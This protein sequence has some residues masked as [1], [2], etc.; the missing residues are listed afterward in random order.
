[1]GHGMVRVK[2]EHGTQSAQIG[3]SPPLV[4]ARLVIRELADEA[5]H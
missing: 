1:M 4:I 3:G 2:T 5:G